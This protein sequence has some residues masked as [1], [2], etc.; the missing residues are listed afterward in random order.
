MNGEQRAIDL[1]LLSKIDDSKE[2][3]TLFDKEVSDFI[4]ALDKEGYSMKSD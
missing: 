4:N 3:D 1:F 2:N